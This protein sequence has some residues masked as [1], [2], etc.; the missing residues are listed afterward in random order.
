MPLS[1]KA[2]VEVYLPDLPDPVYQDLVIELR[3]EFTYT[4]GG[5]TVIGGIDGDYL[6]RL[7]EH[8]R[9]RINLIYCDTPYAFSE[10]LQ[11][12][13]DYADTLE[14]LFRQL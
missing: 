10:N 4:F 2:R 13:S 14:S 12:I 8:I 1:E 9:D 7:G 3:R 11:V 6:S 5:C